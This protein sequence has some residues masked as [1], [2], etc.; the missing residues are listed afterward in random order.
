MLEV[1]WGVGG[2]GIYSSDDVNDD[3][4]THNKLFMCY[5]IYT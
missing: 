5:N 2:G 1:H 3:R 4:Y